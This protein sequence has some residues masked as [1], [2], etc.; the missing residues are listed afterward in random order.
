V[1]LLSGALSFH[2]DYAIGST[3]VD[4]LEGRNTRLLS[5]VARASRFL[6]PEQLASHLEDMAR[7]S[8]LLTLAQNAVVG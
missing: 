2:R 1:Q 4:G 8:R 7:T 6:P 3:R 5:T